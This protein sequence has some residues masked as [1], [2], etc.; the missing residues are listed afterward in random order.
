MVGAVRKSW[1]SNCKKRIKTSDS[2]LLTRLGPLKIF[3]VFSFDL[4]P[5]LL[6]GFFTLSGTPGESSVNSKFSEMVIK[7]RQLS[8]N[9]IYLP[10]NLGSSPTHTPASQEGR[11]KGIKAAQRAQWSCLP[12][13]ASQTWLRVCFRLSSC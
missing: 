9:S 4:S 1:S 6:M 13:P 10:D 12:T 8:C 11:K 2:A 3:L 7:T 5:C